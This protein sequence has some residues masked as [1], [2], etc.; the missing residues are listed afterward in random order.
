M[1]NK[2]LALIHLSQIVS[3]SLVTFIIS[4]N[5][6]IFAPAFSGVLIPFVIW[7]IFRN[8]NTIDNHCKK[9][10]NWTLNILFITILSTPLLLTTYGMYFL[11]I[12]LFSTI[13]YDLFVAW[14]VWLNKKWS[15]PCIIK[16][17]S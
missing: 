13:L 15:Y 5:G 9:I 11:L 14:K 16:F 6:L 7:I 17:F 4:S 3:I 8:N 2:K 10:F 1:N 12:L